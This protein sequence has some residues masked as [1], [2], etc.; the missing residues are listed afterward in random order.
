M[1]AIRTSRKI[2]FRLFYIWF[3]R[4][5][6]AN[7]EKLAF[8]VNRCCFQVKQKNLKDIV[9]LEKRIFFEMCKRQP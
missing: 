4:T 5:L 6:A 8:S 1:S 3:G 7:H 9:V 2:F